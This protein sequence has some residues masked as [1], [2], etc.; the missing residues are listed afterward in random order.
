MSSKLSALPSATSVA[1]TDSMYLVQGGIS[2]Q[3]PVSLL[4]TLSNYTNVVV[5]DS[6]GNGDYTTLSAALAA[7]TD[8]AQNNPYTVFD[9][10]GSYESYTPK[11]HVYVVNNFTERLKAWTASGAYQKT[12]ITYNATYPTV[13]N[14]ATVVWP[15]GSAG[16]LTITTFDATYLIET[17]YTITHTASGKTITQEAVTLNTNGYITAA[18]ELVVA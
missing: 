18:P 14:S 10:S 5:V 13:I 11:A 17:A 7:I 2:K 4:N 1:G 8:A 15:D 3:V 16:V 9:F 6:G 12:A